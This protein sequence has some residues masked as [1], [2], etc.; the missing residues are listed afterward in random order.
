MPGHA[1]ALDPTLA[2]EPR[3]KSNEARNSEASDEDR[4]GIP[5]LPAKSEAG[6]GEQVGP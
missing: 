2:K 5:D 4:C 6:I 3:G 1:P